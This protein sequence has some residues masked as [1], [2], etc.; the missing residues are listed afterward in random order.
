MIVDVIESMMGGSDEY[1]RALRSAR[2]FWS[3]FFAEHAED[4]NTALA[5]AVD[6]AQMPF[7][8]RKEEDAG[9][10]PP[11][12]KSIMALTAIGYLY[13]DGFDDDGELARRVSME[14]LPHLGPLRLRREG[15]RNYARGAQLR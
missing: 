5:A 6:A 3:K 2:A 8:W 15:H 7:Q 10:T 13:K 11:Y 1:P 9:L 12:S 14:R 4:G